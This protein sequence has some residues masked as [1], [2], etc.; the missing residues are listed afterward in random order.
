MTVTIT[1]SPSPPS[2]TTYIRTLRILILCC[3]ILFI[4]LYQQDISIAELYPYLHNQAYYLLNK[5]Y[6]LNEQLLQKNCYYTTI[7]SKHYHDTHDTITNV[8]HDISV[9]SSVK[10]ITWKIIPDKQDPL[11]TPRLQLLLDGEHPLLSYNLLK[12]CL[13]NH[14][15]VFIGDSLSRYQYLNLVYYFTYQTWYSSNPANEIEKQWG[16]WKSFYEEGTKRHNTKDS[17][18]ICDCYRNE[19]TLDNLLENR[20]YIN[21]QFNL[22]ISYLQVFYT[23]PFQAHNLDWLNYYCDNNDINNPS[24]CEQTGCIPGACN[25]PPDITLQPPEEVINYAINNLDPTIIIVNSGLWGSYA[26]D[27]NLREQL[28]R[29]SNTAMRNSQRPIQFYWKTTTARSNL[30]YTKQIITL[31]EYTSLIPVLT[32][33]NSHNLHRWRLFDTFRLTSILNSLIFPSVT[34]DNTDNYNETDLKNNNI[35]QTIKEMYYWDDVH[36]Q[37]PIYRGL[38]EILVLDIIRN[39]NEC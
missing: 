12:T 10:D 25:D 13:N 16:S 3:I 2:S 6:S 33:V 19:N 34:N 9:L 24:I 5:H 4:M 23:R 32:T 31:D 37:Q 36:F 14:H 35:D 20:Y 38:N 11:L 18:E 22:R 7:L 15:I 26:E 8:Q 27:S 39:C 29:S 30:P 1:P 21:Y 17:Y 28:I